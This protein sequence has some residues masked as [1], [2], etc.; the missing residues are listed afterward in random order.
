[1]AQ[2][3]RREQYAALLKSKGYRLV[4]GRSSK[5]QTYEHP[6]KREKYFIGPNGSVSVGECVTRA[7]TLYIDWE[8][9]RTL[10]NALPSEARGGKVADPPKKR[11]TREVPARVE[12]DLATAMGLNDITEVVVHED[13]SVEAVWRGRQGRSTLYQI[14]ASGNCT[15]VNA[16]DREALIAV[17]ICAKN[18]PNFL[19]DNG[20]QV[21]RK[22]VEDLRTNPTGL[23]PN[24]LPEVPLGKL[25]KAL[26]ERAGSG[27]NAPYDS[28]IRCAYQIAT[29]KEVTD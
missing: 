3:S 5:K 7:H 1:M 6:G 14:A 4:P 13:E 26:V 16:L 10:Y 20:E 18:R 19:V 12:Q 17:H 27:M 24:G 23:F 2:V 22:V 21:Y 15:Y 25:R 28:Y 9:V 8:K 29:E 11:P